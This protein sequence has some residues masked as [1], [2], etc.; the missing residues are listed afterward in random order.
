VVENAFY[1]QRILQMRDGVERGESM[2]RVAQSA[3][4]FTPLE[5]QMIGV[6]EET[7]E[8]DEML[9][10]IAK[11]YQD[12]VEYEVERLSESLEPILLAGLAVL[13]LILLL[14]IFL[15][16]WDLGQ[17]ALHKKA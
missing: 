7:G 1:E 11:M 9:E 15:P 10:Q 6:G 17:V 4:I 8:I 12:E 5:L 2:L 16:L 13:V 3:G 14:G